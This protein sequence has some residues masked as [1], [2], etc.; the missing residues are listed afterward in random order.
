MCN[1]KDRFAAPE[2]L[3]EIERARN[4]PLDQYI[5]FE[6]VLD[7]LDMIPLGGGMD[8]EHEIFLDYVRRYCRHYGIGIMCNIDFD[9]DKYIPGSG[10]GKCFSGRGDGD[11]YLYDNSFSGLN[12]LKSLS[13]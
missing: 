10:I 5:P 4:T 2:Y 8:G 3:A 13:D 7:E 12:Q 9:L 6:M 11:A 1:L